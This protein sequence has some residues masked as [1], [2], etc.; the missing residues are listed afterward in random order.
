MECK[1][2]LLPGLL[3]EGRDNL[4]NCL[5][6]LRVKPLLPPHHEVGGLR[7]ERRHHERSGNCNSLTAHQPSSLASPVRRLPN[8]L[9]TVKL[10]PPRFG[11]QA[12]SMSA[13]GP[14][15]E[16]RAAHRNDRSG[17]TAGRF[18]GAVQAPMGSIR[19]AHNASA[20]PASAAGNSSESTAT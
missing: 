12:P 11:N 2:D 1:F 14:D 3:L 8:A 17:T 7:A 19:V 15:S 16:G 20:K 9:S 13:T 5:D 4:R 18:G 6:L 10:E